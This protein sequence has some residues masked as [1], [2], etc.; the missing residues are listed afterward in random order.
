[1]LAALSMNLNKMRRSSSP[2][3]FAKF[4]ECI[5]LISR[6]STEIRNL[7]YLLH[8]PLMD[9]FG[10]RSAVMEYVEGF[11]SRSGLKIAVDV[12]RDVGRLDGNREIA[13]FRVIQESLGN[14][15]RHSGSLTASIRI[16]RSGEDLVLEIGDQGRG[17]S[18]GAEANLKSGVGVR[19]MK[20]RLRPFGGDVSIESTGS[21]TT[22]RAVLPNAPASLSE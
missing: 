9:E 11:E 12:S 3:N 21:G 20:E 15:H 18:G 1:M 17:L 7:S 4:A 16:F 6:A 13:L 8:P 19:S 14:V 10:L 2:E 5:D 22:V